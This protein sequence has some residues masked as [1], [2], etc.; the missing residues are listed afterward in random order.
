MTRLRL[1]RDPSPVASRCCEPI[2]RHPCV[3]FCHG[4]SSCRVD[5]FQIPA[6]CVRVRAPGTV[7]VRVFG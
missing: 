5:A 1:A 4:S 6:G 3:V 2:D 7:R